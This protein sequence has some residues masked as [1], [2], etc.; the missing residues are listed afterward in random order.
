MVVSRALAYRVTSKDT[1]LSYR[2]KILTPSDYFD[3]WVVAQHRL[4][5]STD[6]RWDSKPLPGYLRRAANVAA[7]RAIVRGEL[8]ALSSEGE[9]GLSRI[10][11]EV[12]NTERRLRFPQPKFDVLDG[13]ARVT[14]F[15]HYRDG[16]IEVATVNRDADPAK[17]RLQVVGRLDDVRGFVFAPPKELDINSSGI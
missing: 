7:Q 5:D 11:N 9:G 8:L 1:G 14:M 10:L 12:Y 13:I 17:L 2:L 4:G 3:V 6:G 15:A 16:P